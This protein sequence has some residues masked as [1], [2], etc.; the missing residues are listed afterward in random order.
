M[1]VYSDDKPVL[2]CA[3]DIV[4]PTSPSGG[5]NKLSGVIKSLSRRKREEKTRSSHVEIVSKGGLLVKGNENG[6]EF[7]GATFPKERTVD[8][9]AYKGCHLIIYRLRNYDQTNMNA[10]VAELKKRAEKGKKYGWFNILLH[11]ADSLL[12]YLLEKI[13]GF[14]CDIRPFTRLFFRK[15]MICSSLIAWAY[16]EYHSI[17]LGKPPRLIQPD[18]I[19]DWCADNSNNFKLVFEGVIE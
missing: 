3:G 18:D 7:T 17:F 9:I 6:I 12:N 8:A 4:L 19:D 5:E 1:W 15:N 11:G 10:M 14:R 2:L 13:P 16:K